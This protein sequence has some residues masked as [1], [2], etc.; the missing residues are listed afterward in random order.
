MWA[1]VIQ[2]DSAGDMD[3]SSAARQGHV[4]MVGPLLTT[5]AD[6]N[7]EDGGI[8]TCLMLAAK[9]GHVDVARLLLQHGGT[10]LLDIK[11]NKG[12]TPLDVACGEMRPFLEQVGNAH[13]DWWIVAVSSTSWQLTLFPI[14]DRC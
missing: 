5:E 3:L 12:N 9:E 13:E 4:E 1:V 7:A 6:I 14:P 11:D 2:S 10:G 8:G